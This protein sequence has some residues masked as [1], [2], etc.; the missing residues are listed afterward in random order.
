MA[1]ILVLSSRTAERRLAGAASSPSPR[2]PGVDGRE[3]GRD[4]LVFCHHG[5]DRGQI[6]GIGELPSQ[7]WPH[8]V[9]GRMVVVKLSAEGVPAGQHGGWRCGA[10]EL[11][12]RAA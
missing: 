5:V 1:P 7:H 6:G 2:S 8:V 12:G 11:C 3:G 9:L 10:A 4:L